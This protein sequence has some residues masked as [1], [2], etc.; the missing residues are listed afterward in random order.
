MSQ[1]Q[2]FNAPS[3]DHYP[4]NDYFDHNV[5]SYGFE[6]EG[7]EATLGFIQPNFS[8]VFPV[9]E[10][11][12]DITLTNPV[13]GTL[14]TIEELDNNGNP[15]TTYHLTQEGDSIF[16]PGDTNMRVSTGRAIV[17]Y[18]CVYPGKSVK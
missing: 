3:P 9:S 1:S 12:E 5:I 15:R 17:E 18:V 10:G 2:K 11:G 13:D 8:E 6:V 16:V 4:D 14:L 7:Q